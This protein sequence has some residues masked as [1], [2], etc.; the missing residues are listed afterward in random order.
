ME[1]KKMETNKNGTKQK[2]KHTKIEIRSQ[3]K[4]GESP[5]R[6]EK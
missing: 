3:K 1:T 4:G 6:K 5:N 2:R